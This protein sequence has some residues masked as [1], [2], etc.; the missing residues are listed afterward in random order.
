MKYVMIEI[1]KMMVDFIQT[2][3]FRKNLLKNSNNILNFF[4]L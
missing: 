1:S 2:R 4:I 3:F